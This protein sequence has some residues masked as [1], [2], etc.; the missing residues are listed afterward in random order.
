M[1][2][3]LVVGCG[4]SQMPTLNSIRQ[5]NHES[6][7]VDYNPNACGIYLTHH[8]EKCDIK[9]LDRILKIAQKHNVDGIVVPGTDFPDTGAFVSEQMGFLTISRK[10]AQLCTNKYEQKKFLKSEGFLVPEI[11]EVKDESDLFYLEF[12]C[13]I[14][15]NDNMAA[16][17]SKKLYYTD[18]AHN[19][20][21]N[22]LKY[23]RTGV[24]VAEKFEEGFE[25]SV[26]SLVW[27]G[28]VFVF[29]VA[30][31][32]FDLDPYFIEVGHTM[33]TILREE[34]VKEVIDV[35]KDAVKAL[36]ITHGSAKGDL[37]IS[38]KGIMILEIAARISGGVLSGWTVPYSTGYHPHNDLVQIH[39]GKT[40]AFGPLKKLGFSAER[41]FLSIPGKL[42]EIQ[43]F[44]LSS[45]SCPFVHFHVKDGDELSFPYNNADR[46]GSA[47]SFAL[48]RH[49]AISSAKELVKDTL[50]RLESN[51]KETEK[52]IKHA[53]FD[54]FKT[55]DS[56]TDWHECDMEEAFEKVCIATEISPSKILKDK[57]FWKYF[58]KGG[59]QGGVY[60]IDSYL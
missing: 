56:E 18:N 35:F 19:E 1:S 15:P 33:P 2:K 38:D 51:N 36:G 21:K 40:P 29:A 13:V 52:F 55:I 31:R 47:V 20:F 11:Y 26:D 14:K 5:M 44:N 48:T 25:L 7:G 53:E 41:V 57:K 28:E 24:V 9:D 6:V 58:Y 60:Y 42:K 45:N 54:M 16:R 12:P 49:N 17:G 50:L 34:T 10:V 59:I 4:M 30:D 23:S 8:F 39:L 3:I 22:A 37:K 46:C 32:H 27:N 43:R